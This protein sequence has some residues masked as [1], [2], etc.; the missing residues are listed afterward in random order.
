MGQCA[1]LNRDSFYS[2][3]ALTY[4]AMG[5]GVVSPADDRKE[6]VVESPLSG[7]ASLHA[8]Y[9]YPARCIL[10]RVICFHLSAMLVLSR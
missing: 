6:H 4:I 1:G 8:I 7:A 9:M 2:W 5:G 3:F 10:P